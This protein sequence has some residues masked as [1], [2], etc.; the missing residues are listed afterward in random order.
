[1]SKLTTEEFIER[2]R[3]VHGN[4]YDYSLVN[5]IS[6]H[7]RVKIICQLHGEFDQIARKHSDGHNCR[8]CTGHYGFKTSL[9]YKKLTKIDFVNKATEIHGAKYDY[10]DV[11]ISDETSKATTKLS[12]ICHKHGEFLQTINKHIS[13]KQGCV[14]CYHDRCTDTT[15]SFIEKANKIHKFSFDYSKVNYVKNDVLVCIVCKTHGDF[16][17]SPH[18][19]LK[20][21]GCKKCSESLGERAV[22]HFLERNKIEFTTQKTF[23][24]CKN[25][26]TGRHLKFDFYLQKLNVIV[27][28]DGQQ[29]VEPPKNFFGRVFT[30]SEASLIFDKIKYT[31]EI[32]NKYCKDNNIALVRVPHTKRKTLDKFL[33]KESEIFYGCK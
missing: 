14:L 30:E 32:K 33:V 9:D 21:Q 5:Y 4:R 31:D 17:L 24:D 28:F 12:I 27:E 16:Y 18:T 2:S 6:A 11:V 3:Q 8:E 29:H 25:P 7:K 13:R 20:G 10:S 1:M 23:D 19:H 22:R 15:E 26:K